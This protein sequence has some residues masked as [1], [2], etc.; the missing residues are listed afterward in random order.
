M[1]KCGLQ[2][3]G[4]PKQLWVIRRGLEMRQ[5]LSVVLDTTRFGK[6]VVSVFSV[7]VWLELV[8]RDPAW[9]E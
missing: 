3:T 8:A 2:E 7:V 1:G 4:H 5:K 9:R 6:Q